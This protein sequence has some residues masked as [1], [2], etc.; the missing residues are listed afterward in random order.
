MIKQV[1]LSDGELDI[2]LDID[3]FVGEHWSIFL[4]WQAANGLDLCD[5][6]EIENLFDKFR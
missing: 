6:E 5:E 4:E 2:L 1:E 3:D